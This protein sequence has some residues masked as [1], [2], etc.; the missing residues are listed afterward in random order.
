MNLKSEGYNGNYKVY[1]HI[2]K[3]NKKIY[4]GQTC[5]DCQRRCGT[6]GRNYKHSTHFY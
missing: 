6:N 5:N 3:I 4:I 2:N 1:V